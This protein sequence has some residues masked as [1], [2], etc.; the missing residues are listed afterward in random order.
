MTDLGGIIPAIV[1]PDAR[2]A[3]GSTSPR[4]RPTWS[5]LIEHGCLGLAVNVDTGEGPHLTRDERRRCWRPWSAR[6]R[7]AGCRVV[8]GVGGPSTA[9]GVAQRAHRPGRRRRRAARVPRP[10]VP[11]HAAPARTWWPRTT[12][13]SRTPR[14]CPSSCSSS[15]RCWAG[16]TITTEVL[17]APAG[18]PA[19]RRHQGGQLRS[20]AL[21][22]LKAYLDA[23]RPITLLTGNDNF[24]GESFLLGAEGA[25]LGFATL[26]TREHVALQA[27]ARR[28][29]WRAA[30]EL[31]ARIQRLADVIFAPPVADYRARTKEA[32]AML[33]VDPVRR[34]PPAAARRDDADRARVRA[35]LVAAELL[36]A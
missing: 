14:T 18:H 11:E 5:W 26:L 21:A 19:G 27:A 20:A 16:P 10:R 29:R 12:G 15:S 34:H 8:A 17:D 28:V 35:A 2:R 30:R 33:G 23:A 31:G 1:T 22:A 9:D 3:S 24:I 36:S 4:S 13:P 6:P 7:P 25:L 32:L